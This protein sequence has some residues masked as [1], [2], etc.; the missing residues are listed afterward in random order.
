MW[1]GLEMSVEGWLRF[2]SH[3]GSSAGRMVSNPKYL[4]YKDVFRFHL[5]PQPLAI[6][7]ANILYRRGSVCFCFLEEMCSAHGVLFFK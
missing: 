7:H 2:I 4:L 3:P 1:P 5:S 6:L